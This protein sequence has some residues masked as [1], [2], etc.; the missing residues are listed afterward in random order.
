VKDSVTHDAGGPPTDA[1][2]PGDA[3]PTHDAADARQDV[4]IITDAATKDRA[5]KDAADAMSGVMYGPCTGCGERDAGRD[6]AAK[7]A[8]KGIPDGMTGVMYGPAAGDW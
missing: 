5:A 6:S 8:P 2:V 4:G 1:P 7:D 3:K